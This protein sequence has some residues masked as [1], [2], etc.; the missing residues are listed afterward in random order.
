M[1]KVT[2]IKAMRVFVVMFGDKE[3]IRISPKK[4]LHNHK[5]NI[6]LIKN[7]DDLENAFKQSC[8]DKYE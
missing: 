1:I 6:I 5:D 3:Y 7:C 4:W 2:A 8:G